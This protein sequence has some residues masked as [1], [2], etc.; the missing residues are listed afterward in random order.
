MELPQG[1]AVGAYDMYMPDFGGS[2]I[3]AEETKNEE[4][5]CG[6][7]RLMHGDTPVF[8]DEN[9]IDIAFNDNNL[10]ASVIWYS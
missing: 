10:Y 8:V 5:P 4:I 7:I 1:M 3:D 9:L 2:R 6:K